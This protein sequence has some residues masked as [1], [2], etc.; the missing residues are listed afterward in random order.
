MK[1]TVLFY[2]MDG[3]PRCIP[4]VAL[5]GQPHAFPAAGLT[6]SPPRPC[7][8]EQCLAGPGAGS[9]AP[10]FVFARTV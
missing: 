3:N 4:G 6:A 1:A 5:H 8:A 7:A 2:P 10:V 9:G